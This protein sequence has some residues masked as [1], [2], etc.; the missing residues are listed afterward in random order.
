MVSATRTHTVESGPNPHNR[1]TTAY[2]IKYLKMSLKDA[3]THLQDVR[4]YARP[5]LAFFDQLV[6]FENE[7]T[8]SNSVE[9]VLETMEIEDPNKSDSEKARKKKKK[10]DCKLLQQFTI[11]VVE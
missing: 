2:S 1:S 5:N 8:G 9:M 11:L 4:N 6:Q 10:K 3:F 7:I